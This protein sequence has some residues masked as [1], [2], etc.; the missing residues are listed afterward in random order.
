MKGN[1]SEISLPIQT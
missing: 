1:K